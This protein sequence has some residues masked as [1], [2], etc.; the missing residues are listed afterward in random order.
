MHKHIGLFLVAPVVILLV[1]LYAYPIFDLIRT[2]FF[3]IRGGEE[4]FVGL[5]NY[6]KVLSSDLFRQSAVNSLIWTGLSLIIQ[7]TIPLLLALLLNQKFWG[8]TLARVLMLV[9][10]IT[11]TVVVAIMLRWLL[12][13]NVGFVNHVLRDLGLTALGIDFLGT[14]Q[15]A[16]PTLVVANAWQFLPFGTLL[17]LAGLQTV[18]REVVEA[19][20]VD[21][22]GS[23]RRFRHIT[24]PLLGPV[25]GFVF[26]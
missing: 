21:G 10:W 2:S 6:Q 12:E 22:A 11:P 5:A 25:I 16:L 18:P 15:Y 23:W 8:N 13:P 3:I 19:A 4:Q 14:K 1:G 24:F 7:L 17:I 20:W 26:F 9:P